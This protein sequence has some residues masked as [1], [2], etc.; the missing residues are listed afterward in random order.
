MILIGEK[1]KHLLKLGKRQE[2]SLSPPLF[3]VVSEVLAMTT[4][5]EKGDTNMKGR[6]QISQFV[7]G[8]ILYLKIL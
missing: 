5:Q 3:M 6:S 2:C 1:L 8:M 4:N 7:I